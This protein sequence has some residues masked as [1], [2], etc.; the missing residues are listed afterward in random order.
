MKLSEQL[1]QA[2][3]RAEKLEKALAE[4][5]RY[6]TSGNQVPVERAIIRANDFWRIVGS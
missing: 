2:A 5:K 4:L 3:E 1:R 6:F